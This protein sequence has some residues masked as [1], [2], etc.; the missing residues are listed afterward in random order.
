M[1]GARNLGG[2]KSAL[3]AFMALV[4]MAV[5]SV[6][7]GGGKTDINALATAAVDATPSTTFNVV[8]KNLKFNTDTLVVPAGQEVV[9]TLDNQDSA[10]HNISVYA[11]DGGDAV[12]RGNLF[13]GKAT[14]EYRFQAPAAGLYYFHCDAHPEMKGVFI[15]K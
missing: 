13:Q 14:K 8:A 6:A 3:V 15:V 9:I 10:M 1:A 5:G 7:C 4:L 11:A 12:F 2:M